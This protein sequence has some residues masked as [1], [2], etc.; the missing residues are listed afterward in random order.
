M[1]GSPEALIR[2]K[3]NVF[4]RH[5]LCLNSAA[6]TCTCDLYMCAKIHMILLLILLFIC[7]FLLKLQRLLYF[8]CVKCHHLCNL[9]LRLA[10]LEIASQNVRSGLASAGDIVCSLFGYKGNSAHG[11]THPH[12]VSNQSS[13][14]LPVVHSALVF[15]SGLKLACL[16][17]QMSVWQ[18]PY[19]LCV[20]VL[21]STQGKKSDDWK[22]H[23][24]LRKLSLQ[25]SCSS[26]H[27]QTVLARCHSFKSWWS[28]H[29]RQIGTGQI[30]QR[31][32]L[33]HTHAAGPSRVI[34]QP[35]ARAKLLQSG[36]NSDG[37]QPPSNGPTY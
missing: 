33:A 29:T 30:C 24:I 32:A 23:V 7:C 3:Q 22:N 6:W 12:S 1:K 34:L 11:D 25:P 26:P 15:L 36:V 18:K 37:L 10:N 21:Q 17:E 8:R 31:H 28:S 16:T 35:Y 14:K 2:A 19:R 27:Y 4:N 5:L 20:F 9:S 13:R